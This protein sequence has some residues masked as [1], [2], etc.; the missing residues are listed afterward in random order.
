M[1]RYVNKLSNGR[2][3]APFGKAQD[4]IQDGATH[5]NPAPQNFIPNLICVVDNGIFEAA[6]YCFSENEFRAFAREDGR[7]KTWLTH[8]NAEQ[9]A[10]K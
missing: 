4:L 5:I 3:L 1:G 7:F 2:A 8:P 10:D 6:G 9:I